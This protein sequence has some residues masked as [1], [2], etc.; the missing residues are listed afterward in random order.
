MDRMRVGFNNFLRSSIS[1]CLSARMKAMRRHI[2]LQ[3]HLVRISC[4]FHFAQDLGVRY[5][6]S[7]RFDCTASAFSCVGAYRLG[8]R[9]AMNFCYSHRR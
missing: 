9:F 7:R 5:A 2:A 6:S 4:L 1:D 8:D 3:K